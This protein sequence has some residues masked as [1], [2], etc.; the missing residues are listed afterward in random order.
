M[1]TVPGGHDLQT[2]ALGRFGRSLLVAL[3]QEPHVQPLERLHNGG[4]G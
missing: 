4:G 3:Q 2:R 1:T